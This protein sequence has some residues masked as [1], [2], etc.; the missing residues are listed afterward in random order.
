MCKFFSFVTD[1]NRKKYYFDWEARV[2]LLKNNPQD[3]R[4][5][6]HTSICAK[7][8]LSDDRVNKYEFNPLTNE[9][10][11]DQINIKD[12]RKSAQKWV[13]KLDFKTII[14]PLVIKPIVNPFKIE[15][16]V[17][18]NK[19]IDLLKSWASARDSARDSVW[20]SVW[21]SVN[22]SVRASV[23]A[24]VRDSVRDSVWDSVVDSVRAY[25]S[26]LFPGIKKWKYIDHPE[27]ENPFQP[28]ID[29]WHRGLVPSY[30]GKVWRLHA[31][32]KA[33]I[34]WEGKAEGGR[35]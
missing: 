31:G 13:K 35:E 9:F 24:S 2:E 16:P 4:P 23:G 20:D 3:L 30:D 5:D 10:T 21:D 7:F 18:N 28:C 27:G 1:G 14:T 19:H 32:E 34:V 29:L 11:V 6:S 33:E 15:P 17:I 25:I 8:G 26:S 12:D 22:D